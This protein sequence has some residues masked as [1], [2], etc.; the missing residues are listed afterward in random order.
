[1]LRLRCCKAKVSNARYPCTRS[2]PHG[3]EPAATFGS[4]SH[5]ERESGMWPLRLSCP[6]CQ[7]LWA[8]GAGERANRVDGEGAR[9]RWSATAGRGWGRGARLEDAQHALR[10]D[11]RERDVAEEKAGQRDAPQEWRQGRRVIQGMARASSKIRCVQILRVVLST[12]GKLEGGSG[13]KETVA[14]N[15]AAL[16]QVEYRLHRL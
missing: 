5:R 3:A 1:M 13:R 2:R 7:S 15:A 8:A 16:T 9:M 4:E 12:P 14:G 6:T 10:E 11:L